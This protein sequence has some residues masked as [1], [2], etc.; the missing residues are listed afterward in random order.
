[1]RHFFTADLHAY[2]GNIL[3]YCRRDRWMSQEEIDQCCAGQRF[4][5]SQDS[6]RRMNEAIVLNTNSTVGED[7]V[8]WCVGDFCMGKD[9][10]ENARQIR[11]SIRCKNIYMIW[12]NHD[13]RVI[14]NLFTKCFD[15][16]TIYIDKPTG[17][18]WI[19]GD[20][21]HPPK[22][23]QMIILNHYAM[24]VWNNSHHG[25]WSLHGH[26]HS[27]L[28]PW[29]DSHMPGHRSMDV[30]IDNAYKMLGDYRPFSFEEI[31][32]IM[33]AR[34]GHTLDHHVAKE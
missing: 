31:C 1:M 6:I 10:Y 16:A 20:P 7:D 19:A 22:H 11:R 18:Y 29:L 34:K 28:E 30:G 8:L 26:S 9:Y 12:G 14:E 24:V 17:K 23:S 5:I 33:A 21:G 32:G 13:R 25:S 2:H 3:R 15:M 27:T 4:T